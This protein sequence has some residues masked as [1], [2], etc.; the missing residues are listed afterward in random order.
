VKATLSPRAAVLILLGISS[1]FGANHIAARIAFDHG[2]SVATGVLARSA[3]TGIALLVL[4]R[5]TGVAMSLPR[6]T[7]A[8]GLVIGLLVCVQSFCL[9]SAVAKIPVALALLA[10][11]VFPVLLA[12]IFWALEGQRPSAR[13][14][15]AMALSLVGLAL[16]LDLAGSA[17]GFSGRWQDIGAG[18]LYGFGAAISFAF[19]F[20][21]NGRWM[22]A[23]DGRMR[24]FLAMLVTAPLVLAAGL[25]TSSLALPADAT[26]WGALLLLSILYAAAITVL[27]VVQPLPGM[28]RYTT[29]LNFE[30]IAVLI[31]G[32][33][34][35]GQT[36]KPLQVVG[37][38]MVIGAVVLLGSKK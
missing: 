12:I 23:V 16:A 11:N 29:A 24:A 37:A 4:M 36:V 35:L 20:Y 30:P 2:A 18:V 7:F 21:L 33:L 17:T 19:V 22:G 15:V 13:A 32:Y 1:T 8:R 31:M 38:L 10:F 6:P 9:F 3:F 14:L 27:F 28:A 5:L 25:A 26:G 34:I